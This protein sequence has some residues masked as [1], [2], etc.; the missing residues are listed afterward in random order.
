M[1]QISYLPKNFCKGSTISKNIHVTINNEPLSV[2][3]S[4]KYLGVIIDNKLQW[5]EL[6]ILIKL[7]L[8]KGIGLLSKIRHY[9]LKAV[10]RRSLYYTFISSHI[11][12][13]ILNWSMSAKKQS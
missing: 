6:I 3:D 1:S 13:N 5:S 8:S 2:V 7:K 9:V 10:L 12:Y 4:A 11:D